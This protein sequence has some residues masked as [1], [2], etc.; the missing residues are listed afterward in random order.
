MDLD[1][2]EIPE[3]KP[4]HFSPGPSFQTLPCRSAETPSLKGDNLAILW[5]ETMAMGAYLTAVMETP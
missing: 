1:V 5:Y 2:K 4:H 3:K